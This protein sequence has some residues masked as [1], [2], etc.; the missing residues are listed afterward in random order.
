[1][2]ITISSLHVSDEQEVQR[3]FDRLQRKI[4]TALR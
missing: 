3:L 1:M 4:V 2:N